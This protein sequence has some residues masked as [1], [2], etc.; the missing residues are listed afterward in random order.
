MKTLEHSEAILNAAQLIGI[1]VTERDEARKELERFKREA[2]FNLNNAIEVSFAKGATCM[3]ESIESGES[4]NAYFERRNEGINKC[5]QL[6][7]L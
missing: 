4:H 1:Y 3:G 7:K 2:A 5:K 6:Y